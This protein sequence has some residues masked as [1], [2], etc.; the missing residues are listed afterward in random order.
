[1]MFKLMTKIVLYGAFVYLQVGHT[2]WRS[3]QIEVVLSNFCFRRNFGLFF[4]FLNKL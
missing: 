3:L 4:Q 2:I 1:M